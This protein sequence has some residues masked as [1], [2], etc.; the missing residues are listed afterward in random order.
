MLPRLSLPNACRGS[1]N[2]TQGLLKKIKLEERTDL[3]E[4][5]VREGR[6]EYY[7]YSFYMCV[8]YYKE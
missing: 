6:A 5:T 8:V 2:W 3:V 7:Q 1:I 4:V